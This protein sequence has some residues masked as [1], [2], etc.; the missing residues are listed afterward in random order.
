L[1]TTD[2]GSLEDIPA[3]ARQTGNILL[4]AEREEDR[5]RFWIEK[6]ARS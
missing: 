4:G 1:I 2:P 5:Q 3:L 6:A